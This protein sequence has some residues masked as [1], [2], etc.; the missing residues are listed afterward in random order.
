MAIHRAS[1]T[2]DATVVVYLN[3]SRDS[4]LGFDPTTAQLHP[5]TRFTL[6]APTDSQA[7]RAML[8]SIYLQL[9][10]GGDIVTAT[11][12]TERYRS[13]GNRSLSVGDVVVIGE[14][15]FAVARF[16]FDTVSSAALSTAL[17]GAAS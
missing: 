2:N 17:A 8:E 6:P 7:M 4:M 13:E 9:N 16:G 11:A 14:T 5:A 15:A 1:A 10:V 3:D 12:Y